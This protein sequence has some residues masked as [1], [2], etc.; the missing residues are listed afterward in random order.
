MPWYMR[1]RRIRVRVDQTPSANV[2]RFSLMG[3]SSVS[4][5]SGCRQRAASGRKIANEWQVQGAN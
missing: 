2:G 4:L 5:D 3:D 1:S